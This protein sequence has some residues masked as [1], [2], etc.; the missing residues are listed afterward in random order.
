MVGL[1]FGLLYL[2][3]CRVYFFG[4]RLTGRIM[5]EIDEVI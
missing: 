3:I 1:A 4:A 2:T 5:R